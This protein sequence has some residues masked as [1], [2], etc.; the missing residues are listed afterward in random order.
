[1]TTDT[2]E[3]EEAS[4]TYSIPCYKI[5]LIRDSRPD[6]VRVSATSPA[7][8]AAILRT[9]LGDPDVE[10]FVILLLD[11]VNRPVGLHTVAIGSLNSAYIRPADAFKAAILANAS[12]VVLC[13]NHPSGDTTPSR[14]DLAVTRTLV[15]AGKLLE[16]Q[17]LDHIILGEDGQY[18]SMAERGLVDFKG[19]DH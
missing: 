5:Q 4:D 14:D 10:H 18:L 13:H 1:M 17:V 19:E 8:A 6:V 16:L 9:F 15:A 12:S 2:I 3:R 7:A 11:T